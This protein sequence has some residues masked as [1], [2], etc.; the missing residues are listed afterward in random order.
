MTNDLKSKT[1][2]EKPLPQSEVLLLMVS[3]T[4]VIGL[5]YIAAFAILLFVLSLLLIDILILMGGVRFGLVYLM[6]EPV[7]GLSHLAALVA[8]SLNLRSGPDF[9]VSLERKDAPD[10]FRLVEDVAR[11]MKV[12]PPDTIILETS[13]NAWVQLKGYG[14]GKGHC[15]LGIG[16]DML[17]IQNVSEFRATI[18]HE[19]AHA[20]LVQRG[21]GN[22]LANGMTRIVQLAVSLAGIKAEAENN[23]RHFYT[24]AFLL[25]IANFFGKTGS[26]LIGT[27]R[28]QHEFA[29]DRAAAIAYGPQAYRNSLLNDMVAIYKSH[30]LTWRDYVIQTQ[31]DGSFSE[32]LRE[33]LTT[34]DESERKE[35]EQKMM[36]REARNE[37][38]THPVYADRL[39][40]LPDSG[41]ED[42]SIIP[43]VEL[44][45][46]PD[47]LA[48]RLIEKIERIF[49]EEQRKD[50]ARIRKQ[51][52]SKSGEHKL[53]DG[54]VV[55]ILLVL[56]GVIVFIGMMAALSTPQGRVDPLYK[57]LLVGSVVGFVGGVAL[58]CIAGQRDKTRLLVPS[59]KLWEESLTSKDRKPDVRE[60]Y[61]SVE[62]KIKDKMPPHIKSQKDQAAYLANKAYEAL[63]IC[64]YRSA[65]VASRLCLKAK[66]AL[67]EGL[68]ASAIT[69]AY[70]G[71]TELATQSLNKLGMKYNVKESIAWCF[72][73]SATL[74]ANWEYAEGQI[75]NTVAKWPNEPDLFSIL[76]FCQFQ[77]GKAHEAIDSVKR[78]VSIAPDQPYHRLLLFQLLVDGGKPKDALKEFEI[79]ERDLPQ[80]FETM[81]GAVRMNLMLG[82]IEE[83]S[84]RTRLVE[85]IHP[86]TKALLRLAKLY[87]ESDHDDEARS[88][89]ERVCEAG[90]Y[91]EA[92]FGMWSLEYKRKD[93][94]ESKAREHLMAAL[95]VTRERPDDAAGPLAV[96]HGVCQAMVSMGEPET[97]CS[98]WSAKIDLTDSP[99]DARSLSLLIAAKNLQATKEQVRAIYTAMHPGRDLPELG[100]T[101]EELSPD[102]RPDGSIVP[103]IYGVQIE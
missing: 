79:V 26:R 67:R 51:V 93:K 39:A 8:T 47:N 23:K 89:C 87:A 98:A 90:F 9:K 11:R 52:K 36:S 50:S 91:P 46:E 4:A 71:Q 78:A 83:A 101:Y 20:K 32:W 33:R 59:Y 1:T 81:L 88:Y 37:Y 21:Y 62:S 54:Q 75:L 95:D 2:P 10:L 40:A 103:G 69:E 44:L 58:F 27:Y 16:Y 17:V 56:F 5:F 55:G 18:A 19:M 92:Q 57:T 35:I 94:D 43:A 28:R 66:P 3:A 34:K 80:D 74:F 7:K 14:K 85:Q 70:F 96:L 53:T 82:R 31:R 65:L 72:A 49:S 30:E 84:K 64:D 61:D 38:D 73:W 45:K 68:I 24:A 13:C 41:D 29:A 63:G 100:I 102:K 99:A 97:G 86:G 60:W 15:T 77:R 22:W 12:A 76:G 6:I 48:I 25:K 42:I